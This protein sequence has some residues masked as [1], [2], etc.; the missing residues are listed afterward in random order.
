MNGG[1]TAIFGCC[2][3]VIGDAGG[4][5]GTLE[6]YG[7]LGGVLESFGGCRVVAGGDGARG[8]RSSCLGGGGNAV[9]PFS[10]SSES[11]VVLG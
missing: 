9:G 6:G 5:P 11:I 10:G 7:V 2:R 8:K 1:N 3:V 4:I